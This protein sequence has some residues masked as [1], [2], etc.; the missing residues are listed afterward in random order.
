M[1]K[2]TC[3]ELGGACDLIFEGS[4]FSEVAS[5]SQAHGMIMSKAQDQAHLDALKEMGKLMG[6]PAAMQ[7]WMQEKE[8]YFNAS[9]DV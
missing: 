9:P 2:I 8:D 7:K 1:K 3:R 4:T 5:Q 6:E